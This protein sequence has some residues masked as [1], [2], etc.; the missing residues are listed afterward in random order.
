MAQILTLVGFA[1]RAGKV[2]VGREAVASAL[3]SGRAR[4]LI[5]AEDASPKLK[6]E[7]EKQAHK[8][9]FYIF[10][11][12]ND[13][14][15]ILGREQVSVLAVCDKNLAHSIRKAFGRQ[16]RGKSSSRSE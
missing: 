4:V 3:R 7:I 6:K 16:P 14:G 13:L 10:S 15:R 8:T 11:D 9:P 1:N 5:L 12:K 2:V